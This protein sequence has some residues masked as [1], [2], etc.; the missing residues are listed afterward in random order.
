MNVVSILLVC[1]VEAFFVA[2]VRGLFLDCAA[3]L[4]AECVVRIV[5][6][7]VSLTGESQDRG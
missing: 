5:S 7:T 1:L 4:N 6:F 3:A 2:V